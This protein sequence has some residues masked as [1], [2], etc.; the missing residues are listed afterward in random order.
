MRAGAKCV[1]N[2]D[3]CVTTD[4]CDSSTRNGLCVDGVAEYSCLCWPGW[5]GEHSQ[6]PKTTA[7]VQDIVCLSSGGR[8]YLVDCLQ[9]DF[10]HNIY[11]IC[12]KLCILFSDVKLLVII[13]SLQIMNAKATEYA[14]TL[15]YKCACVDGYKVCLC[16]LD[17]HWHW[18]LKV[19]PVC[20][21][22]NMYLYD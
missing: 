2:A 20:K 11:N 3:D 15:T 16:E 7:L 17:T 18:V 6:L 14:L 8:V 21:R 13:D 9:D 1:V 22:S 10:Q 12:I 4:S 19:R 5:V